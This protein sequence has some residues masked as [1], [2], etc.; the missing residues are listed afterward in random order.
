MLEILSQIRVLPVVEIKDD[1][2]GAPLA[3][4]FS[5]GGLNVFEFTMRTPAALSALKK[6][7]KAHPDMIIGMGTVLNR[8]QAYDAL[9][10][11]ADFLV[12]PGITPGLLD[13][14]SS[15]S[16]PVLLGAATISDV[17]AILDRDITL[18][19]FFPAQ[20]AGGIDYLKSIKGPLGEAK[21]CAT[22]GISRDQVDDF[23]ALENIVC[24][25]GS[26][27]ATKSMIANK[28]WDKITANA[29]IAVGK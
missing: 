18:M 27:V 13:M 25:G 28:E 23:L 9:E 16:E 22:G 5:A 4:A 10:A 12:T 8:E 21:F 17:M 7:K 15:V 1:E 19:K 2:D 20:A 24:V 26:W 29:A 6:A 14:A 3:Q 11:G